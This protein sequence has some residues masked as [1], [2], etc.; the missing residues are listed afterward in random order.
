MTLSW[1]PDHDPCAPLVVAEELMDLATRVATVRDLE[2]LL[3]AVI[4][5]ARRLTKAEAGRILVLDHAVRNL[6]CVVGQNDAHP[7]VAG[8]P[9]AVPVYLANES[10][11][12]RD[13]NV[14]AVVTGKVVNLGDVQSASSFDVSRLFAFERRGG[15]MTRSFV[16][17]PLWRPD[18][19]TLGVLQ[20]LNPSL[21]P[22]GRVGA[23]P[24][25]YERLLAS[26]AAHAA[27][28]ITNA[29]LFD[30]NEAL[31]RHLDSRATRL[32]EENTRLR[33]MDKPNPAGFVG[34]SAPMRAAVDLMQRAA[35]THVAV[36]LLGETG[37]G[38]EVFAR[39]IHHNSQRAEKPF[40]AQNC[41]ALPETLLESELF[42]HRKGAFT[43]AVADKKGLVQEAEGGTLFLDEIGDMPIGLQAKILRML[44]EGS[45]RR[46][47]GGRVEPVNVRVVAA[48]N[49][50]LPEKIEAG[51]FRK[52]LF[53]RLNVFPMSLPPLRERPSDVPALADHFLVAMAASLGRP[54]PALTP[55]ALDCLVGWHWPGN[56]RELRNV[57]ERAL[58]LLDDGE[59]IDTRHLPPAI[60]GVGGEVRAA[61]PRAVDGDL[62]SIMQSYEARIIETK[63][64]ETGWNQSRAARLLRISR[65]SLID[66]LQRYELKPPG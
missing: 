54:V 48:T 64:F 24:V 62:R 45:I 7:D 42:G 26:F 30:Q 39:A 23:L 44:E 59:R 35:Q 3:G 8:M 14:Y 65:R 18:R 22:D 5:A 17:V 38:K 21:T 37:T 34:N 33:R 31:I 49:V 47:G 6:H 61:P 15:F 4:A 32:Q 12:L 40:I 52:D 63:L 51:L 16:A 29:R 53:Y 9:E 66:K 11:N 60:A 56:V 25:R 57:V 46:V 10:Y 36:L 55:R 43:G 19:L 27:V 41:A 28:A 20:I 13:P 2:S 50:N 58:V 1:M